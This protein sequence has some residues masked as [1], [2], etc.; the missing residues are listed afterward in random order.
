MKHM[1]ISENII[2]RKAGS[3]YMTTTDIFLK[4]IHN[5]NM[6]EKQQ[7]ELR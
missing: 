4:E 3:P 7:S 2:F 6:I 1:V 5:E